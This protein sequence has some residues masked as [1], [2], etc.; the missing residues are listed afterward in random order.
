MF[1]EKKNFSPVYTPDRVRAARAAAGHTQSEAAALIY[2]TRRAWQ[3]WESGA[4]NVDPAA[5]ELYLIKTGQ[6]VVV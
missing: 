4:R 3:D 2:R 6:L 1:S 5:F